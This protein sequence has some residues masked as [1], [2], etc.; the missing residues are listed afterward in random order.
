[1]K[2]DRDLQDKIGEEG[3]TETTIDPESQIKSSGGFGKIYCCCRM[4]NTIAVN[5]QD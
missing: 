4:I 5:N 1:M 3:Q 2:I